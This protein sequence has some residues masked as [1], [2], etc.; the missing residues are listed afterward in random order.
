MYP[1]SN[2]MHLR[3]NDAQQ[4]WLI[5]TSRNTAPHAYLEEEI[6]ALRRMLEQMVNEGM[7]MTADTVIELSTILDSKINEYMKKIQKAGD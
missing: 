5:K 6:Q 3:E 4:R 7:S 2:H 1:Y